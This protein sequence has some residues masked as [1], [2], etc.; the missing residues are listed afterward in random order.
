MTDIF[1]EVDEDLRRDRAAQL[2]QRYRLA[3][4][5]AAGF[6]VA[7]TGCYVFWQDYQHR[8]Q[9]ALGARFADAATL[10]EG[11]QAKAVAAYEALGGN[12]SQGY[13]L[14]ARFGAAGL[15][16]KGTDKAA[17]IAALK[18][19]AADSSVPTVYRDLA[20]LQAAYFDVDT[21]QPAD[22]IAR[23]EPLTIAPNPWRFSALEVTALAKLK[24]GDQDAARK[25]YQQLADDLDAPQSIR[26]RAAEILG[27]FRHQG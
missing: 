16:A 10:A 20:T 1:Q 25:L 8:Q 26:A 4:L 11:D 19:I 3:I 21:A 6:V 9:Q 2:W 12:G 5:G 27:A 13:P 7:A 24:S 18:A 14:L 17:G 15:E 22:I 23:V